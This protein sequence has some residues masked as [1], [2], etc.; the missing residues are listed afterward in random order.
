MSD[1]EDLITYL[2]ERNKISDEDFIVEQRS[3]FTYPNGGSEVRRI[4]QT[5][6][7]LLQEF[8]DWKKVREEKDKK[9]IA[10]DRESYEIGEHEFVDD[11][12]KPFGFW[13]KHCGVMLSSVTEKM[14]CKSVPVEVIEE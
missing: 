3:T 6:S 1:I 5:L 13:C 9:P 2:E 7:S 12:T 14:P 11:E 8:V 10:S 4:K